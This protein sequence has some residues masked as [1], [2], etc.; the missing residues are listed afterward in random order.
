[1]ENDWVTVRLLSERNEFK[2]AGTML[3]VLSLY[4]ERFEFT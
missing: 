2:P 4:V 1:M 3:V